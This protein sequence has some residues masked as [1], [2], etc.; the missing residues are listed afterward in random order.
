MVAG[1]KIEIGNTPR[2]KYVS[3]HNEIPSEV[4]EEDNGACFAILLTM[5]SS[6]GR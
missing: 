4:Y 2:L 3:Q 6:S 5:I 1:T